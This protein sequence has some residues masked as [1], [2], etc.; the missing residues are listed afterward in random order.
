MF[1]WTRGVILWGSIFYHYRCLPL[2]RLSEHAEEKS[3][4]QSCRRSFRLDACGQRRTLKLNVDHLNWLE[5]CTDSWQLACRSV[6]F[7][8]ICNW[9]L[10]KSWHHDDWDR[11]VVA[12][13]TMSPWLTEDLEIWTDFSG[14]E[15]LNWRRFGSFPSIY[16]QVG[17]SRRK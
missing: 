17:S 1:D 16:K 8:E 12:V 5:N 13:D 14:I 3:E 2:F 4:E 11:V 15:N 10:F 7:L 9:C 6:D